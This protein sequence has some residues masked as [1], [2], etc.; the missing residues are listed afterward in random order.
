[1]GQVLRAS[2]GHLCTLFIVSDGLL[3]VRY[4]SVVLGSEK[5]SDFTKHSTVDTGIAWEDFLDNL[6]NLFSSAWPCL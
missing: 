4:L 6:I 3:G 2:S 5:G 1:M